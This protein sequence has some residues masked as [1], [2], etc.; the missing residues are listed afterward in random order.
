MAW[1]R[2]WPR[3][4]RSSSSPAG[5]PVLFVKKPGG[6]LHLCVDYRG[7]NEGTIK[8][9]YPLPLLREA[10]LRL[11]KPSTIRSLMYAGNINSFA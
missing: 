9:R 2:G 5:A 1:V 8:N 6:G 11:Q 10:L 4:I 7:L 3:T